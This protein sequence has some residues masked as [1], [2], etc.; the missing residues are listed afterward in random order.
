MS[1]GE[2]DD[3]LTHISWKDTAFIQTYGL[4]K[5]NVMAYFSL[6]PFFD[7]SSIKEQIS[8]QTRFNQLD[9]GQSTQPERTITGLDY[10]L[11]DANDTLP[12]LFT[13]VKGDRKSPTRVNRLAVYYV[14]DGTIY[15][16]P[17][18]YSLLSNRVLNSLHQVQDAFTT[19][20]S[21]A[22]YHPSMGHYWRSDEKLLSQAMGKAHGGEDPAEMTLPKRRDT[23][24]VGGIPKVDPAPVMRAKLLA[25]T[26]DD[27][28]RAGQFASGLDMLL[29]DTWAAAQE[30]LGR[31]DENSMDLATVPVQNNTRLSG[32]TPAAP[33]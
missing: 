7:K 19:L 10:E 11:L 2:R 23:T 28:I 27:R 24:D 17:D 29:E 18:L 8:M 15:Q 20:S 33:A 16:A 32:S 14:I 21:E 26:P 9:A 13:I 5:D 31:W 25:R 6:S 22:R 4:N 12:T 30:P 1:Y 3:D